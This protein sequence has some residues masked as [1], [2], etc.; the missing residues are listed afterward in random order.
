MQQKD[1]N[2]FTSK[3]SEDETS[4]FTEVRREDEWYRLT[5]SD[6]IPAIAAVVVISICLTAALLSFYLV[7]AQEVAQAQTDLDSVATTGSNNLQKAIYITTITTS[8]LQAFVQLSNLSINQYTQFL[9]FVYSTGSFPDYTYVLV[10]TIAVPEAERNQFIE[11]MRTWGPQYANVNITAKD[12]QGNNIPS[13]STI[14]VHYVTANIAPWEPA[15]IATL[16][17]DVAS[18]PARAAIIQKAITTRSLCG[19]PKFIFPTAD[20]QPGSLIYAPLY[21]VNN[22]SQPAGTISAAIKLGLLIQDAISD[23]IG[24]VGIS[25][26]DANTTDAD[27]A[28][29]YSSLG[30][31]TT[32]AQNLAYINSA[33]FYSQVNVQFVDRLWTVTF[34]PT[35]DFLMAHSTIVKYVGP[36]VSTVIGIILLAGCLMLLFLKRLQRLKES[37]Q[38]GFQQIGKLKEMH[39]S[40]KQLLERLTEQERRARLTLDAI[41]DSVMVLNHEGLV[42][43]SNTI[44]DTKFAYSQAETEKGLFIGTVFPELEFKFYEKLTYNEVIKTNARKSSD[45]RIEV[46]IRVRK[47]HDDFNHNDSGEDLKSATKLIKYTDV[48]AYIIIARDMIKSIL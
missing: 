6:L 44:F 8:N 38:R 28:L 23:L 40:M 12:A 29:L 7:Q 46:E 47:L 18:Q 30:N 1:V 16:G 48:E 32:G 4:T 19:T 34:I 24:T 14:P 35:N 13:P 33:P 5:A 43:H 41:P 25:V 37:R 15:F 42:I 3:R 27:T 39:N 36:I 26:V 10:R 22:A 31:S 20:Q 17:F 9:P 11:Y 2:S 21:D 45:E